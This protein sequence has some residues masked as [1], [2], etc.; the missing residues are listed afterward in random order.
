[1]SND[2]KVVVAGQEKAIREAEPEVR[3]Q[4]LTDDV[5]ESVSVEETHEAGT[6]E[7]D[8]IGTEEAATNAAV[9]LDVLEEREENREA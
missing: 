7:K 6:F 1:M 3:R 2:K 8:V 5:M 9:D 4:S